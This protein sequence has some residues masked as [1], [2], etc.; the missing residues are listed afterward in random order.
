MNIHPSVDRQRP[1]HGAPLRE[2]LDNVLRALRGRMECVAVCNAITC[3]TLSQEEVANAT[4]VELQEV[5][6]Q[7]SG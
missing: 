1:R 2:K 6:S 7:S 3:V 4:E 5:P